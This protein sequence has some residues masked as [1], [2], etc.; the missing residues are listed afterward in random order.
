MGIH[1][2][3]DFVFFGFCGFHEEVFQFFQFWTS[4]KKNKICGEKEKRVSG[5]KKVINFWERKKSP[6][7]EWRI[8]NSLSQWLTG[9][10]LLGIPYFWANYSD[11]S[12]GHPKWWFSKGIP[13]K[14]PETFRF[15]NYMNYCNL[16]RY[17]VGKMKIQTFFFRV[18]S[19]GWVRK[20]GPLLEVGCTL[21][22]ST[23]PLCWNRWLR[24]E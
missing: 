18:C 9:F 20:L 3:W 11:L 16:A 7:R 8:E 22:V 23:A 2:V 5:A 21:E 24:V 14:I 6:S 17:L 4:S 10:E 12:R 13:S 1:F 15:R 19:D